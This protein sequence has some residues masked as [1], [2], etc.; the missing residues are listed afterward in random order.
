V[1]DSYVQ[2][3]RAFDER[4]ALC[5]ATAR[6]ALLA[7]LDSR[8]RAPGRPSGDSKKRKTSFNSARVLEFGLR[9]SERDPDNSLVKTFTCRLCSKFGKDSVGERKRK[10]STNI[11]GFT[12]PFC[13]DQY[14]SHLTTAHPIRWKEYQEL[15]NAAKL[16]YF[17]GGTR[18]VNTLLAHVEG[19]R[20]FSFTA[21]NDIIENV[22]LEMYSGS[23]VGGD[24][25]DSYPD[26]PAPDAAATFVPTSI[27]QLQDE[28]RENSYAVTIRK[29]KQFALTRHGIRAGV[30][31]RGT[32][33]MLKDIAGVTGVS[34]VS[35][36][37]PRCES[38]HI[39]QSCYCFWCSSHSRRYAGDM[40]LVS[41]H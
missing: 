20:T 1:G 3:L 13:V 27:C 31:F 26:A 35:A 24:A 36:S 16:K 11:K 18:H 33:R 32:S 4:A 17:E 14:K 6:E 39:C 22:L 25:L 38:L 5:A 37:L 9:I 40:G 8:I 21:D 34:A 41:R 15:T 30:S 2:F 10:P 29:N 12:S 28:N 19:Y 23:S 7:A